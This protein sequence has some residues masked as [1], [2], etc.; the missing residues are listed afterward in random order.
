MLN[1]FRT[2]A[3]S[4]WAKILLG[5]LVISFGVWGVGD[6]VRSSGRNPTV[7]TVGSVEISAGDYLRSL[8]M[9]TE[10]L[11]RV[12]GDNFSPD[13]MKNAQLSHWVLQKLVNNALL[14]QETEAMGVIPSDADVVRRIRTNT[15]FQDDK[16]NFD[17][18]LYE[19]RLA[20]GHISEQDYVKQLRKDMAVGLLMDTLTAVMPVPDIAAHTLLQVREEQRSV[21][22]YDLNTS[23]VNGA[24]QPDAAQIKAYYDAH[25]SEFTA[26]EYR[27]V[28]YVVVTSA[29]VP[30][31]TAVSQDALKMLYNDRI[32]EFRKP[33]RR[34]VEQLLYSSEDKARAA[35]AMLK[36][37]KS[38]EQ[39]AKE[40]PVLNKDSV[41]M[42]KIE[43]SG[44]IA[45]AEG[46]VFSLAKGDSTDP[47]QSPFGWHIF[48]VS[49][50]DPPSILSF[51]EVR[52]ALEK[53]LKQREA[54]QSLSKLANKIEDALAGGNT[55]AEAAHDFNLK[56][57]SVGPV[58]HL[59]QAP[60]GTA[61]KG[62]PD[63][64]KFLQTA[65][66]TDEKSESQMMT[67]KGGVF[68]LLRVD[69][70]VPERL[71]PLD[72]VKQLVIAGCQKEEKEKQLAVLAKEL[73]EKFKNVAGREALI[74][75]YNL[76]PLATPVIK[77]GTRTVAGIELPAALVNAAFS[78]KVG[79]STE[80][81]PLKNGDYVMAEVKI[82]VPY[83]AQ[84][85]D[86][87]QVTALTDIRKNLETNVQNEI[88]DQYIHYLAGK[89][90]VSVNE[91]ALQSVLK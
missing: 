67:A 8:H 49:E 2:L 4:L 57:L 1:S 32:E 62:L 69:S 7:A 90:P 73:S 41:S 3:S 12:M 36:N 50:I 91:N 14:S 74:A 59:G 54:D 18:K 87:K 47:I 43:R 58:N 48:H 6:M 35:S 42:G 31:D 5:L 88:L 20:N 51:E 33:E 61:A 15:D 27:N 68:Y 13:L 10:N 39:V 79:Q 83:N 21:M 26:P 19:A 17:K 40:T 30:K 89:Y 82:I 52:P 22:L 78:G 60:D 11:R 9:E 65:F 34:A 71:K 76:H 16:G 29:D 75:K 23:L 25:T 28:S 44:L 81:Y 24:G 38:F 45:A 64:D 86:A 85:K 46:P 53:D 66:K 80:A 56:V 37:G 70:I 63:F 55:L 84:D 72:E 77:R